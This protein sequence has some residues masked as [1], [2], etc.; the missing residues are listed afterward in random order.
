MVRKIVIVVAVVAISLCVMG[1]GVSQDAHSATAVEMG[2]VVTERDILLV[3]KSKLQDDYSAVVIE[4]D[5]LSDTLTELQE[6]CPLRGFETLTEFKD[7]IVAHVQQETTYM[8]DAVLAAYKVQ[9]AG[10]NDGYLMGIDIEYLENDQ[11]AVYVTVF[12]GDELYWWF[13]E[14]PETYGSTGYRR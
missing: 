14:E 4:R 9:Q 10:M 2:E 13:V 11:Q 12:V 7:W 6:V 5:K 1:C 8:E 3:E